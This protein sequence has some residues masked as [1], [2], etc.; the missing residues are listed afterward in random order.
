MRTGDLGDGTGESVEDRD[1]ARW[2]IISE[3][4]RLGFSAEY[5]RRVLS[6]KCQG[7]RVDQLTAREAWNV[8][9][10]LRNRAAARD[11][12]GDPGGRNQTQRE[13]AHA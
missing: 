12:R 8:V 9:Y 13:A 7:R 3:C 4:K 6:G 1:L 11:G 5:L 2:K 10:T